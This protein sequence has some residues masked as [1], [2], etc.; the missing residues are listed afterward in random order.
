MNIHSRS[1]AEPIADQ[2]AD[3]QNGQ[4]DL[5]DELEIDSAGQAIR[6]PPLPPIVSMIFRLDV[7]LPDHLVHHAL[8]AIFTVS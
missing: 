2:H 4:A 5:G 8:I 7:R 6:L 3:Q 1:P